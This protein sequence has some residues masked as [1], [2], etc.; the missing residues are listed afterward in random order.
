[1]NRIKAL[2]KAKNIKQIELCKYLGIVQGTLSGWENEKYEPDLN[3]LKKMSEFFGVSIDYLLGVEETPEIQEYEIPDEELTGIRTVPV[4]GDV[5]GGIPIDM[6]EDIQGYEQLK[7]GE[8][9]KNGR[10]FALKIK[11]DSMDTLIPDGATVIVKQQPSVD[12]GEI[13]V[14]AVN[15]YEATCKK[16]FFQNN[17]I[18]LQPINPAYEPM[19]YSNEQIELEPIKILGKVIEVRTRF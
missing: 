4:L 16:V 7:E 6:I 5:A 14:V 13:A 10:Y 18:L 3:S 17:G 8:Y 15:G 1:M 19:F 9:S 11:G 2:R 12:N